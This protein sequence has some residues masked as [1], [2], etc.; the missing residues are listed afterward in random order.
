MGYKKKSK[1]KKGRSQDRKLIALTSPHERYYM[2]QIAKEQL[3]ILKKI[4]GRT[5]LGLV[6]MKN[7]CSKAKLI[8]ICKGILKCL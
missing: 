6:D 3:E 4:D 1:T 2:K 8:R 5:V 7:K